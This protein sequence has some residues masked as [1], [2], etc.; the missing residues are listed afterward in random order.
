MWR[1]FDEVK[2]DP[3]L[4]DLQAPYLNSVAG[5]DLD[6]KGV[7]ATVNILHPYQSFEDDAQY[8]ADPKKVLYY[9]NAWGAL[10]QNYEEHGIIPKGKVTPDDIIWGGAIWHQMV[11]YKE[12]TDALM[13]KLDGMT[14]DAG[15]KALVDKAKSFYAARDYLDAW[16]LA[17]A[18]AS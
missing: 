12:K 15:K 6:G 4:Y 7:A 18:A 5:T 2:K 13:Q 1:I 17:T 14:I 9:A 16:R 3:S 10:I 11:D 8:Y